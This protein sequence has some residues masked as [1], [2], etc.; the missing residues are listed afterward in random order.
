MKG[1][2]TEKVKPDCDTFGKYMCVVNEKCGIIL[3]SSLKNDL[4]ESH[5]YWPLALVLLTG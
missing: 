1:V 3:V 4:Q 2:F 5:L